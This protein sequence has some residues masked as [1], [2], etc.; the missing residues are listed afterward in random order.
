M[1]VAAYGIKSG[2]SFTK[3]GITLRSLE[4]TWFGI[5]KS[6]R[7][8]ISQTKKKPSGR[9]LVARL[10]DAKNLSRGQEQILRLPRESGPEQLL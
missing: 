5:G 6:I 9:Y 10:G 1:K 3:R 7:S 8:R 2:Q 4:R